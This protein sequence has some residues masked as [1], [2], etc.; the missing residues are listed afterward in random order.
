M[1]Y[2]IQPT[3]KD[4]THHG[5]LGQKWGKRQGPPYPLDGSD[6]SAAEKKAGWKK[7]LNKDR[8]NK[9]SI[10]SKYTRYYNGDTKAMKRMNET[11]AKQDKELQKAY[12]NEPSY[13][14]YFDKDG[15]I[16]KKA[17]DYEDKIDSI[18][19]KYDKD[20]NKYQDQHIEEMDKLKLDI[21]TD[22]KIKDKVK[23]ISEIDNQL[24]D[25]KKDTIGDT[26]KYYQDGFNEYKK[27]ADDPYDIEYG[28]DHYEW[29]K[30]NKYYDKAKQEYDKKS[31]KQV[32]ELQ[33]LYK[34]IGKEIT[35][36]LSDIKIE[37]LQFNIEID[38]ASVISNHKDMFK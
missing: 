28:F 27:Q 34:D 10:G 21:Y 36:E 5:I 2:I 35:G 25:I 1:H 19:K 14:E 7:S 38:I 6:H 9:E 22:P 11:Y 26:S 17:R 33:S 8:S 4:I 32:K 30:G 15:R 24:K 18:Y 23:R 12:K 16:S 20:L 37:D 31:S 13:E 3:S 29:R